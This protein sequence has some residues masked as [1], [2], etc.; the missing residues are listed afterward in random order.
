MRM[1]PAGHDSDVNL[2]EISPV[3]IILP[4]IK[5]IETRLNSAILLKEV[6]KRTGYSERWLYNRFREL[7]GITLSQYIRLRKLTLAA[8]LLRHTSRPVTD[9]AMMYGFSSLQSF[10]R[11]FYHHYRM[12]PSGYR[13]AD[14]WDLSYARPVLFLS[15]N[16]REVSL[17]RINNNNKNVVL[18]KKIP[19]S[20][21]TDFS[22]AF[23]KEE[24]LVYDNNLHQVVMS[25]FSQTRKMKSFM[26][27]GE[28]IPGNST[29]S[30]L[31]YH[32]TD[33][34]TPEDITTLLPDGTYAYLTF[35]GT[36]EQIADFQMY[37][38]CSILSKYR[39]KIRRGAMFTL[40]Q[41]RQLP[42]TADIIF[43]IPCVDDYHS[44]LWKN[45]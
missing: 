25:V 5:L 15:E 44:R 28:L 14:V 27:A 24:Q 33:F 18:D 6:A 43:M 4:V 7:A 16:N 30:F 8:V 10:S 45:D 21:K 42:D 17:I 11:A 22:N 32:I 36:Y 37:E 12:S 39:C 2:P 31:K 3:H 13:R 29:D 38:A 40:F 20:L 34:V 19:V 23:N 9:I 35:S 26:I 1:I 41:R